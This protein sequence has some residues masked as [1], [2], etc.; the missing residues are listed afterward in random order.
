MRSRWAF[1]ASQPSS[2]YVVTHMKTSFKFFIPNP[3]RHSLFVYLP[4]R[5]FPGLTDQVTRA[6]CLSAIGCLGTDDRDCDHVTT[7]AGLISENV[8]PRLGKVYKHGFEALNRLLTE[9]QFL[10][11]PW[12]SSIKTSG[13]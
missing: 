1:V 2:T 12:L 9:K 13:V 11:W 5:T 6:A 8:A 7:N 4:S 10:V 3:K